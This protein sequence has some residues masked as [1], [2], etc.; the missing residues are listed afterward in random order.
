MK[1]LE[2]LKMIAKLPFET[3][4]TYS[5]TRRHIPDDQNSRLHRSENLVTWACCCLV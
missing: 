5:T 3:S 1:N 2:P 4:V